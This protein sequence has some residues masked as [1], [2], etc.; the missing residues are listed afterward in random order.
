MQHALTAAGSSIAGEQHTGKCILVP[1]ENPENAQSCLYG[2]DAAIASVST[3]CR[4]GHSNTSWLLVW[5][6]V[7]RSLTVGPETQSMTFP[8]HPSV[9]MTFLGSKRICIIYRT[10]R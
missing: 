9:T 8:G 10:V 6:W 7:L 2:V 4:V 5:P 3:W 1:G